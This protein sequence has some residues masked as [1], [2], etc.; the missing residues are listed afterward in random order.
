MVIVSANNAI[1]VKPMGRMAMKF[2]SIPSGITAFAPLAAFVA[3]FGLSV[4]PASAQSPNAAV[5]AAN[6]AVCHGQGGAG[7][8]DVV[9]INDKT[10]AQITEAMVAFRDG[11]KPS[12]IMGRIAKGYTDAQV[13][14][15]ANYIG[16][17]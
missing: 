11:K 12:T 10:P 6:C 7:A 4:T 2:D 14:A 15:V 3:A 16:K 5:I 17:K 8:G 1:T 13:A 9:K